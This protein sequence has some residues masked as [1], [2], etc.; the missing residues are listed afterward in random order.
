MLNHRNI[1]VLFFVI[2]SGLLALDTK[3]TIH[4]LFY[5]LPFVLF[6]TVEIYGAAFIRS[7]FHIKTH[8]TL[9][10]SE[11]WIVLSFDDG[12]S[13]HTHLLLYW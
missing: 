9:S 8:S 11:K 7:G 10:T 13:A 5:A 12:P 4:W 2:T 1:V 6:L 3:Y